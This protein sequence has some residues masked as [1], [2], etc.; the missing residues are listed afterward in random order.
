MPD[1]I[2]NVVVSNPNQI[3]TM[4]REFKSVFNGMI[5][6][7]KIDTDP[8]IP[9]NQIQVYLENEDGSYTPM[10]QPIRTNAGGYPVYNGKVSKFVT[11][12]GHC[13]LIQDANGVQLFYF[14]NV[15]KYDPDQF[16]QRLAG[17]DGLR[18]IG[19][20][21]DIVQLRSIEP[22]SNGQL[23]ILRQHTL[24][25]NL[26]GGKFRAVL[27]A[28]TYTDNNGTVVKTPSGN[29]WLRVNADIVNPLMFGAKGDG[30]T[31]DLV[32]LNA[33]IANSTKMDG[34][35]LTY[36]ITSGAVVIDGAK[37]KS[38]YN[39][40]LTEDSTTNTTMMRINSSFKTVKD[41]IFDGATGLTSRGII[42]AAG[43]T[44]VLISKNQFLNLKKYA[45]GVSGDYTNN[46][47]CSRIVIDDNYATNCGND[48]T[49]FDRNTILFDGV[50]TCTLSNNSFYNCN[51]G[52]QFRQPYNYPDLTNPYAF[53]N[54]VTGNIFTGKSGYPYNQ[55]VSAQ[56]QK[57]FEVSGN[58]ITGFLGNTIDNQLCDFS[59]VT[60]NYL[61]SGDDGVFFGDLKCRGHIVDSN[62]MVGCRRGI[63]VYGLAAALDSDFKNQNMTD[64]VISNNTIHDSTEYGI[65]IYRTEPTFTFQGF[66]ISG[67]VVDNSG[68]RG[69]ATNKEG[70]L[71][72]GLNQSNVSDNIVRNTRLTGIRFENAFGIIASGNNISGYDFSAT[73]QNGVYI[74]VQSRG[75]QLRNTTVTFAGGAG[76]GVRETGINNTVTGT[77]WNTVTVGVNATGTG[78]V[79]ADNVA[80]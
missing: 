54:K 53:Y 72:T 56:S 46:I 39:F 59:R 60:N 29:A 58:T 31:N 41:L 12:E 13:M 32:P 64:I 52:V 51:W 20:C 50:N 40:K 19:M 71:I 61:N 44:D 15:L 68:T 74:D 8:T 27:N 10:P 43:V 5:Y 23:I 21:E 7:G 67:N 17:P 33:A 6:I 57:H 4:P 78:V 55:G 47:F 36:L 35:G 75:V 63:R 34:I 24:G 69:L 11:V 62:V 3:F 9:A 2:P 73:A 76:A 48:A 45:V 1:I 18:Y 22:L 79:V 26:G 16:Q 14:P 49:N 65:Y 66:V 30:V 38:V 25:T 42:V 80:F 28:T 37:T 70:I 77:R